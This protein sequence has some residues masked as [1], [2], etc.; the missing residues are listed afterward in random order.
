M[1]ADER[2][3][4]GAARIKYEDDE[5]ADAF[6]SSGTF[7]SGTGTAFGASIRTICAAQIEPEASLSMR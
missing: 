4:G 1:V 6:C 5:C 7:R 3:W 2:S